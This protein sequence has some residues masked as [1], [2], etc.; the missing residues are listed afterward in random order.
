M[1]IRD[2]LLGALYTGLG[3]YESTHYATAVRYLDKVIVASALDVGEEKWVVP[4]AQWHRAVVELKLGD[5]EANNP[6]EGKQASELWRTRF[7]RAEAWLEGALA[8][9]EFDLKTRVRLQL[10]ASSLRASHSDR[11]DR[12][13]SQLDSRVLML[14][15]EIRSKKTR[16]GL[17]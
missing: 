16:L 11:L 9:P 7:V 3:Y 10:C 1:L 12:T 13:L 6:P 17:A 2:L 4:F 5:S 15:E 14:K 8:T